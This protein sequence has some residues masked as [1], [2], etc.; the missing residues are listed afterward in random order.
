MAVEPEL[1]GA[2]GSGA[3]ILAEADRAGRARAGARRIRLHAQTLAA[4]RCTSARAT[5]PARTFLEEGI[6]HVTMEKPL[7]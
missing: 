2:R 1:R 5:Q 7:A 4:R 3:A 6:E